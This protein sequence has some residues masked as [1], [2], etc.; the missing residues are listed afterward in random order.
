[1]A[2]I[3]KIENKPKLQKLVK[4]AAY[5][6]V[7]DGKDSMHR[8]LSQQISYYSS[9]IQKNPCWT[10]AGVY[11]DEAVTG[12]KED[13][14]GFTKMIKDAKAGKI[15]LI[16]TKSISRFA[17]NTLTLLQTIRELKAIDV[18]VYF[19][20]QNVY[21][22]SSDGEFVISLLASYAQEESRNCSENCLWRIKK[23][24][25]EG[26][27]YGSKDVYGYKVVDKKYQV[28]PKQAEIVKWIY[29][30]FLQGNGS[31][32]ITKLL[33]SYKI[34]SVTGN[35]WHVHDVSR[36]LKNV[37]Y[38][39]DLLLQKTYTTDH[40]TKKKKVNHGERN[41][42]YVEDDH[43]AIIPKETFDRV[44]IELAERTKKYHREETGQNHLFTSMIICKN[45]GSTLIHKVSKYH[46]YWSCH[47]YEK[48]GKNFCPTIRLRED[49]L[50]E[51][52]CEALGIET[53][54]E[55]LFKDKIELIKSGN[56]KILEFYFKDGT[57]KEIQWQAVSRKDSWTPEMKE[58]ARQK[59]CEWEANK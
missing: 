57:K 5:A 8:S 43:E 46:D 48:L 15:D 29:D 10:Y 37:T 11:S 49:V 44:Q 14:K 21:T 38:K 55:V 39:G 16:I 17:R 20:E 6:R 24:F 32:I 35:I 34:P 41:M 47:T 28:V 33:N 30:Y 3:I 45:C 9:M 4:V 25:S 19:E 31:M 36:I 18:D 27:M 50:L 58:K 12:T 1:M 42:Y 56:D 22:L 7:S 40:I 54:D 23:N 53:F 26:K 51:K 52:T 2:N 13:R 59:K